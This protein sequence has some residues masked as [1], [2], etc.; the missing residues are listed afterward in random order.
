MNL[1]KQI[2]WKSLIT[3]AGNSQAVEVD[4]DDNI[5]WQY[6]TNSDP[7]SI[8]A[9]S[10]S[11]AIRLANGDTLISDQFNN[12]VIRVTPEGAID[13]GYGL[14]LTGGGAIGNNSSYDAKTVQKGL[15]GPYDAKIVGDYTGLTPASIF[16]P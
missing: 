1:K 10:P 5:V 2:V 3:D 12:R 15:Y 13:G 6:Q 8:S 9:P 11:R 4:P 14:P 7:N 16:F